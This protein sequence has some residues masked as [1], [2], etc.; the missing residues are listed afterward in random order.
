MQQKDKT[1]I[2]QFDFRVKRIDENSGISQDRFNQLYQSK[3]DHT[4]ITQN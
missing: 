3:N 2:A 1:N 4:K